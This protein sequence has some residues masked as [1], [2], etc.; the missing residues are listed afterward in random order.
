MPAYY[1][2]ATAPC[3]TKATAGIKFLIHQLLEIFVSFREGLGQK[4]INTPHFP[5]Y[6]TKTKTMLISF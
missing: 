1:L 5:P 4:F 3:W 6:T 2:H